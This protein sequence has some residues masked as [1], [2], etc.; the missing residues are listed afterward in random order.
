LL[1]PKSRIARKAKKESGAACFALS[2]RTIQLVVAG[3]AIFDKGRA[4]SLF[5]AETCRHDVFSENE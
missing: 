3:F 5:A 2:F 4:S 1:F